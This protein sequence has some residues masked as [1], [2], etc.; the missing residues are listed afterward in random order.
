MAKPIVGLEELC[1]EITGQCMMNCVHCSSSSTINNPSIISLPKFRELLQEAKQLGTRILELSGGEPLLH[2]DINSFV[3]EAAKDFKVRL[4]TS[5]FLGKS[6]D[7]ISKEHLLQFKALG[8]DRIIFN[9]EGASAEI[10]EGVSR[11]KGSYT[12]VLNSIKKAK[13]AGLWVGVHFVPM[14]INFRDF[15]AVAELCRQLNVV[16]VAVLRFVG[17][18]RGKTNKN[19]LELNQAEF[20]QFIN[21]VVAIRRDLRSKIEIRTGC[22]MNFCSMVDKTITPVQC[23]AGISTLLISYD[24]SAV[25]CPAFKHAD[26]FSVANINAKS[27]QVIWHDSPELKMLRDLVVS[28]VSG[29]NICS[30]SINC[31][32]RCVAQRYYEYGS[33]YLG[34]DPLCPL[35]R[36]NQ[37]KKS[38]A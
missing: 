35:Q 38:S 18:G 5:G 20:N 30:E 17:Q 33:I 16:E 36:S 32:G 29:C 28:K 9:L 8:L 6:N 22:P 21:E 25:P 11:A 13:D 19:R 7:G 26:Q 14:K 23:K 24:G 34:P 12:S 10:H 2:P 37:V 27:L 4:Y 31:Q 15:R 3:Q 1:I